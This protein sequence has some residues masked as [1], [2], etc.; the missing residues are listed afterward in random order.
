MK[1]EIIRL[2]QTSHTLG[3]LRIDGK[4]FCA[5]L[6]EPWRD[7]E[8]LVS[9]IPV[10]EYKAVKINSARFG[11]TLRIEDVNGRS[12]I[13]FHSGNT[14]EDTSGCIILGQYWGKLKNH[15]AVLNSG[16]TFRAFQMAIILQSAF[17]VRVFGV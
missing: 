1:I 3:A 8:R 12:G 6:E 16:A 4:A 7:N 9:C 17:D 5:T 11:D 2:E 10:G 14:T 13:L 15:R